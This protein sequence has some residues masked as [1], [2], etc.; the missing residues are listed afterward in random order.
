[1]RN[2]L[3]PAPHIPLLR[4]WGAGIIRELGLMKGSILAG[5]LI[6]ITEKGKIAREVKEITGILN[7]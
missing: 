1:M 4:F 2:F 3:T 6:K 7:K 5:N